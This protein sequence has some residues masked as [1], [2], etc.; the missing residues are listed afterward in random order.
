MSYPSCFAELHLV[1]GLY[2]LLAAVS[3]LGAA[4]VPQAQHRQQRGGYWLREDRTSAWPG[5]SSLSLPSCLTS[6]GF[7][8]YKRVSKRQREAWMQGGCSG[9]GNA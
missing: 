9:G 5:A 3:S 1:P 2:G 7:C 4:P 8:P 6:P